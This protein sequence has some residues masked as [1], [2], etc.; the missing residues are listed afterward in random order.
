MILWPWKKATVFQWCSVEKGNKTSRG[1][2]LSNSLSSLPKIW[3]KSLFKHP[4]KGLSPC[5]LTDEGQGNKQTKCAAKYL[6]HPFRDSAPKAV[7]LS[8]FKNFLMSA[9]V[10]IQ[11]HSLSLLQGFI[12][13]LKSIWAHFCWATG[14]KLWIVVS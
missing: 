6:S 9:W 13:E 2:P 3:G 12:V 1:I 10:F 5:A 14:L 8:C 4:V 7:W 11:P